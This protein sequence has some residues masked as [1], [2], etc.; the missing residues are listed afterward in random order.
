MAR[1]KHSPVIHWVDWA[2]W[3]N[4]PRVLHVH[5]GVDGRAS[6][7]K[8]WEIEMQRRPWLNF[9]ISLTE[10]VNSAAEVLKYPNES[11]DMQL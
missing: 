11:E 9:N 1:F 4:K 8:T 3:V 7:V 2:V 5:V 10:A 6:E